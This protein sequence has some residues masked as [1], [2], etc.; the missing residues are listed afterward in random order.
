M[1]HSR[2]FPWLVTF[3][4][5]FPAAVLSTAAEAQ[6]AG[7]PNSTT[8]APAPDQSSGMQE[9]VVTAEF[10]AESL[11]STP[12]AISAL[13]ASSLMEKGITDVTG[14]TQVAPGVNIDTK[15]AYGGN[16]VAAYIRGIG[17]GDYSYNVEPGVAFYVDDVYLGPSYGS[18]LNLIDLDRVEVLRGPQGD[19]SGKNAIGGAVRLVTQQPKG[20]DSG[21]IQV[22]TGSYDLVRIRA[23]Y[24][25]SLVPGQLYMRI[26]GY[27]ST[28]DG[29]VTMLNFAC[30]NP[31]EVGNQDAPYALKND[32]PG[33]SCD[34]GALGDED[35]HAARVQFRWLAADNLEFNLSGDYVDN[36]SNGAADVLIGMNPAGFTNYNAATAIPLYGV[37]YDTR[38]LPPNHFSTYATF[39]D[40]EYG[41]SFPPVDTLKT[42][43]VTLN[44]KWDITSD[45][46][47]TSISAWRWYDGYWSY[48]SDSSPLA[49]DGVYD[50]E[51]HNQVSEELRLTGES[52]DKRLDWTV[53]AFYYHSVEQDNADVEAAL[54]NLYIYYPNRAWDTNYAGFMHGEFKLTDALTF[55]GGLRDSHEDK[56][57][58]FNEHD[59]PGTPSDVFPGAGLVELGKTGYNHLDYRAGL[60]YQFTPD[61]M[62]YADVSTGFRAGGFN[63]RPAAPD[64]VVPYGPEKLTSYEIG[65]RNEFF[66]HRVRFNN[67][68][69]YGDYSDIQLTANTI[70]P[71][72][73]PDQV[74]TNAGKA[75]I[76]GYETELQAQVTQWFSLHGTGS[77]T[78]FKYISLG[79]AAG[80]SGGPTL[81]SM[82]VFTPRW[83]LNGGAQF[84][85]PL[86]QD[87]GRMTFNL[88]FSWQ[89]LEFT[90]APNSPQL[91]IPSYGL[92]N[93][94]LT[95]TTKNDWQV[96][97]AG[98][99]ITDKFYWATT[100]FISGDYQWKGVPGLPAQW[101]LSLRKNF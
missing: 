56:Q 74:V 68:I 15:G 50:N 73:F 82:Q 89:S 44:S 1:S 77:Y 59:I 23:A 45:I 67:T 97:L 12:L 13:S 93:G 43:A 90:D 26:S 51:D 98:T 28:H 9:V 24:D 70:A 80:V 66:D 6:T 27:S 8:A 21:Y 53:G 5:L 19:L 65:T 96:S 94:R 31:G 34:R 11:Q 16:T 38:F 81:D 95:F 18:L 22:E 20:D 85:L 14:L 101:N 42:E 83:K 61:F 100:N 64:E 84:I 52:F 63:P 72:G 32:A 37:P 2:V 71:D 60:Q 46:N 79:A 41:L 49:T 58:L 17:A 76:Y 54:Y 30:E 47:L 4:A 57:F 7:P 48:D 99:N 33:K 86:L 36:E 87:Y 69:Y 10:R 3:G 55:I 25:M 78:G 39:S 62:G 29:D 88:D 75:H 40:P 92:L 35:I 91:E